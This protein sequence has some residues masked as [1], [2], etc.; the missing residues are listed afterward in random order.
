MRVTV[1]PPSAIH[2]TP[3]YTILMVYIWLSKTKSEI[4]NLK[5]RTRCK[6]FNEVPDEDFFNRYSAI[7]TGFGH[8]WKVPA[9]PPGKSETA[10]NL[11]TKS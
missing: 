9:L 5:N 6:T 4:F 7:E 3:K 2:V 8:Q 10:K 11:Y 1:M